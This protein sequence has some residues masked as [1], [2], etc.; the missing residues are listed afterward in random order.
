MEKVGKQPDLLKKKIA[1]YKEKL[2][3]LIN[4]CNQVYLTTH[5][6]EDY[7]AIASIGAMALICKRLKKAPYIVVDQ[8]DFDSLSVEK[9]DMY[10]SLRDKN[11]III[12][13]EDFKNNIVENSLLIVLD[14]N[15]KY[16][17]PLKNNYEDF[18]NIIIFDHHNTD[19]DT[20]KTKNN[21]EYIIYLAIKK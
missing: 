10:E 9:S 15:K 19:S 7:D 13:L 18:S 12:N 17:T 14:T 11:F 21:F 16:L 4:D 5:L 8:E 1:Q 2:V 3:K 20:I 6:N